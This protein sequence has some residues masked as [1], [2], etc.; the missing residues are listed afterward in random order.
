MVTERHNE[1]PILI[2]VLWVG[3]LLCNMQKIMAIKRNEFL[4][5]LFVVSAIQFHLTMTLMNR[6]LIL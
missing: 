1:L 5:S 4:V 6:P 3:G 2:L